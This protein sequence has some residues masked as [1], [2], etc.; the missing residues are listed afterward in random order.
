MDGAVILPESPKA[1]AVDGTLA[2]WVAWLIAHGAT[3][4]MTALTISI[5]FMRLL[6]LIRQWRTGK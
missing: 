1:L 6:I 2:A 3:A 5:L 4:V